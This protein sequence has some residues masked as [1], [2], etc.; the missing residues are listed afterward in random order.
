LHSGAWWLWAI[1]MA[2]IAAGTTNPI[3]LFSIIFVVLLVVNFR[4]SDAPWSKSIKGF[5]YAGIL[6]VVIRTFL[7]II[8]PDIFGD[9]LLFTLPE[10]QLP[11]IF[12]GIK[13]GGA[14]KANTLYFAFKQGLRFATILICIGAAQSLASPYR[15][16]KSVPAA[17]Y[18]IGLSIIVAMTFAPQLAQDAK[19]VREAQF[20]RGRKIKG[21]KPFAKTIVPIL[22]GAME[23]ALNLASSMDSRGYGRKIHQTKVKKN[24]TNIFMLLGL[25]GII[26]GLSGLLGVFSQTNI[27]FLNLFIGLVFAFFSLWLAGKNASR[28]KYRADKWEIPEVLV[29][30]SAIFGLVALRFSEP[31]VLNPPTSPLSFPQIDLVSLVCIFLALLAIPFSPKPPKSTKNIHFNKSP[32]LNLEQRAA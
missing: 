12:A 24:I 2:A 28:T 14:I 6:I 32:N 25:L 4:K 29:V 13:L 26:F 7:V 9:Y 11:S 22:E 3:Y 30:F 15:L 20:L 18:E 23:R 31:T 17:L 8:T 21:I 10:I 5:I 16:L 1:L 19:R 27:G